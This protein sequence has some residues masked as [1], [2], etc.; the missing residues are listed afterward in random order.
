[1]QIC[2]GKGCDRTATWGGCCQKHHYRL[3]TFGGTDVKTIFDKRS[4]ITE[5]G[6]TRIPIGLNAK[7]GYATVDDSFAWLDKYNWCLSASGYAI[8]RPKKGHPL[9]IMHRL[10]AETPAGLFA[11]HINGDKLDNRSCNLRNAT[12]K[13][14]RR[15]VAI[16]KNNTTGFKGVYRS[17]RKKFYA[18]ITADYKAIGLGTYNTA[19]EAAKAYNNAAR[20]L[21]GE[22]ARLNDV[23]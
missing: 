16:R 23:R 12:G 6:A 13:E 3:K 17:K 1:M 14:N 21:H 15:N 11:D 20:E 7:N 9:L 4:A 22:F 2:I 19:L 8:S 5:N 18:R 10:V